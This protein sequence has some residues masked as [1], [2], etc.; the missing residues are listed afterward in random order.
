MLQN[1][2]Q[3]LKTKQS[4]VHLGAFA[5]RNKLFRDYRTHRKGVVVGVRL[6]VTLQTSLFFF[7]ISM[8]T[9]YDVAR[10][11]T[12]SSFSYLLGDLNF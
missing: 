8:H 3:S 9:A 11:Y 2:W 6:F 12:L 10:I 5:S 4:Q 7:I 1:H